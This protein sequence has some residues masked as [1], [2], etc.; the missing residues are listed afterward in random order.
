[1]LKQKYFLTNFFILS[2]EK[3]LIKSSWRKIEWLRIGTKVTILDGT[4]IGNKCIVAAGA[5]VKGTYPDNVII[6]GVPAKII[7]QI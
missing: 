3:Q 1:M 7:R 4:K 5:V 6:G 2:A